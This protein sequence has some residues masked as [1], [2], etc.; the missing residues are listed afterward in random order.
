MSTTQTTPAT[1]PFED[2]A[3][4]SLKVCFTN[5]MRCTIQDANRTQRFIQ[6]ES[7]YLLSYPRKEAVYTVADQEQDR[8]PEDDIITVTI[9]ETRP[10]EV[11]WEGDP[12]RIGFVNADKFGLIDINL[13]LSPECF[14]QFWTATNYKVRRAVINSAQFYI[15]IHMTTMDRPGYCRVTGVNLTEHLFAVVPVKTSAEQIFDALRE[16][17]WVVVYLIAVSIVGWAIVWAIRGFWPLL[18]SLH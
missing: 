11:L 16:L 9:Y 6:F 12:E 2:A 8:K 13:R 3:H 14:E 5:G 15:E 7:C 10:G 4:D 1:K 17:Q 18:L